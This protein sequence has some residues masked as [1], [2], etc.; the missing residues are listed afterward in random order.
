MSEGA[1]STSMSPPAGNRLTQVLVDETSLGAASAEAAHEQE[2]AVFDLIAE[3]VFGVSGVDRG[4]YRLKLSLAQNRLVFEI[5]DEAG[6]PV[7][8]HL[9]SLTPFRPVVAEYQTI[10]QRHYAAIRSA[11]PSQIEA[12]DMGRRGLHNDAAKLLQERLAG[13]IEMDFQTARRLFTLFVAF[14]WEG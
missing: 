9:L 7:I 4:P 10:C 5:E 3:N 14:P 11:S 6:T 8:A 1:D 2:I 13:K 12:I